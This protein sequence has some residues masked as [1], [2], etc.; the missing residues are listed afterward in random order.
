MIGIRAIASYI[1]NEGID[2]IL[3]TYANVDE[4][5]SPDGYFTEGPYYQR[6]A[7]YPFLIF[8]QALENKKPEQVR[9]KKVT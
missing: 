6:Y 2:N 8:A 7:S 4:P 5:F 3:Q 9:K 1:P